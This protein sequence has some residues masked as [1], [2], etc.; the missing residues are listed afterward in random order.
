MVTKIENDGKK[1]R[2]IDFRAKNL[3]LSGISEKENRDEW[4]KQVNQ[5]L[6]DC[7]TD[8]KT[9]ENTHRLGNYDSQKHSARPRPVRLNTKSETQKWELLKRVNGLKIRGVFA[10]LDLSKEDQEK[11]FRLRK[12]LR[13]INSRSGEGKFVIR[14]GKIV[15]VN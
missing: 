14:R 10:R 4:I 2:E 7:H 8:L 6:A 9:N 11:D 12:E 1:E 5:I 3:I 15:K 13:E